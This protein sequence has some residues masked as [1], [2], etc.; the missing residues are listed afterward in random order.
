MVLTNKATACNKSHTILNVAIIYGVYHNIAATYWEYIDSFG[1][2]SSHN[3]R[4]FPVYFFS[5]KDQLKDLQ[6]FDVLIL[7]YGLVLYQNNIPINSNDI[8]T[9]FNFK[10]L[11]IYIAQDEY[12]NPR[13]GVK[14]LKQL[15]V[16]HIFSCISNVKNFRIIYSELELPD[17]TFDTVLTGY[18]SKELKHIKGAKL[19]NRPLDIVYRG[20][21]LGLLFGSLGAEK[22]EIAMRMK[23]VAPKYNLKFDIEYNPKFKI[24]GRN[25]F[26]FL[27]KGRIMLC[28]ESGSSIVY[29]DSTRKNLYPTSEIALKSKTFEEFRKSIKNFYKFLIND[30]KVIIS[31]V[32]PKIFEAVACGTVLLGYEGEYSGVIKPDVHYIMLKK[33]WSNIKEVME[34]VKDLDFLRKLQRNAYNDLILSSKYSYKGFIKDIDCKISTLFEANN[35]VKNSVTFIAGAKKSISKNLLKVNYFFQRLWNFYK[36]ILSFLSVLIKKDFF[37]HV[38]KYFDFIGKYFCLVKEYFELSIFLISILFSLSVPIAKYFFN[39]IKKCYFTI[40]SY[41]NNSMK[42]FKHMTKHLIFM[43]ISTTDHVLKSKAKI[44]KFFCNNCSKNL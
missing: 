43:R 8:D 7:H 32:S 31:G 21:N 10:G 35:F 37:K 22:M 16:H 42:S 12:T 3:I 28:T 24:F 20:N 15:G 11:K 1:K 14:R 38:E 44:G 19:E 34:K 40:K 33:D 30:G 6:G 36:K 17:L 39:N 5:D 26:N 18:V 9:I 29:E 4:Y 2:Y 13:L 23:E 27:S 41:V 25:W